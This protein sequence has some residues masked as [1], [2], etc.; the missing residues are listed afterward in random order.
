MKNQP[1]CEIFSIIPR[2]YARWRIS[3]GD[4]DES[5]VMQNRMFMFYS[6]KKAERKGVL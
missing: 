2:I 3:Y 6:L 5:M 4:I 1:V